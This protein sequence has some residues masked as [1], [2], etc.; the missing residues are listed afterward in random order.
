MGGLEVYR[1]GVPFTFDTNLWFKFPNH[2]K[3]SI[4]GCLNQANL[5]T[6]TSQ[7]SF[8]FPGK[9]TNTMCFLVNS[10]LEQELVK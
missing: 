3:A 1:G 5:A 6:G 8:H 2:S 4:E 10:A 9:S 7:V